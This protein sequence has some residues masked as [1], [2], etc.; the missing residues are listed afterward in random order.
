M[1]TS[2]ILLNV[3]LSVVALSGK[4]VAMDTHPSG[5]Q[6][7]PQDGSGW[8]SL[9]D[10]CFYA[11]DHRVIPSHQVDSMHGLRTAFGPEQAHNEQAHKEQ[12]HNEQVH[13]E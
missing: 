6:T 12:A 3:L 7:Q 9:L 8:Y 5:R 11:G 4:S 1:V 2:V 10:N 13:N